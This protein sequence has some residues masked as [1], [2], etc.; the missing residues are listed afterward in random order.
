ME[1]TTS[2]NDLLNISSNQSLFFV[3][4]KPT[5]WIVNVYPNDYH[6]LAFYVLAIEKSSLAI[7]YKELKHHLSPLIIL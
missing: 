5:Y 1:T 4:I 2:V 6:Y 3:D 7:C